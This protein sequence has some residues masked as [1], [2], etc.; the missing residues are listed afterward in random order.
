M[1]IVHFFDCQH[2][3][4][5]LRIKLC[6]DRAHEILSDGSLHGSFYLTLAQSQA[7]NWNL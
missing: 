7:E 3:R 1:Y 5:E 6:I 4:H 2:L